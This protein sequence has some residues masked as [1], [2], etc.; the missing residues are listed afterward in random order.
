MTSDRRGP[1]GE[2]SLMHEPGTYGLRAEAMSN[3]ETLM[4]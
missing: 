1:H 3:N 4:P 2:E